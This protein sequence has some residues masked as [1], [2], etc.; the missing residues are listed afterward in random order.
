MKEKN[1]H[2][3]RLEELINNEISDHRHIILNLIEEQLGSSSC[4]RIVR[5]RLLQCF[6]DRGL[7]G[8]VNTILA[9]EFIGGADE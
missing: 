9:K 7:T 6:G 3:K 2:R 1:S 4:W 8:R 5:S